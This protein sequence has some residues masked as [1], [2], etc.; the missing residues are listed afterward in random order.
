MRVSKSMIDFIKVKEGFSATLYNDDDNNCTIG[1]GHLV[2]YG[3]IDGSEP[4][5]MKN[6]ITEKQAEG[7]LLIELDEAAKDV[8]RLVKVPLN[9]N[10]FDSLVS[11][12]FNLGEGN[13]ER[14]TLLQVLNQGKYDSVPDQ[15][16]R[17]V[18]AGGKILKGLVIRR[19]QEAD[20]FRGKK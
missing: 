8:E 11:F 5:W 10:Q 12:C 4:N 6:G 16:V 1:Y 13:L 17:W 9:Q 14:S 7:L 2:H 19:K 3:P 18:K 15:I 20:I